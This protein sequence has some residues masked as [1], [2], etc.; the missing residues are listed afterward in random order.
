M[1]TRKLLAAVSALAMT[2][3][4]TTT[5]FAAE[6]ENLGAGEYR[7]TVESTLNLPT[8]QVTIA[9]VTEMVINPYQM[10]YTGTLSG[11]ESLITAP[12]LITNN[13]NIKVNIEAKPSATV[14]GDVN[15]ADA[16]W[17]TTVPA[18]KSIFMQLKM[19]NLTA[20]S[21]LSTDS[22]WSGV[23][24]S[25]TTVIKTTDSP[26]P[27]T[28]TLGPKATDPTYGGYKIEGKSGGEGWTGSEKVTV[29]LVFDIKAVVG[30]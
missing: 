30:G 22:T 26:S 20:S 25:K 1:K 9:P 19:A 10:E 28:L 3:A 6:G 2:L 21:D 8:I 7:V 24:S 4:L 29:N 18:N 5:A 13:S 15:V 27:V 16:D 11:N 23:D 12:G 14:I 17:N